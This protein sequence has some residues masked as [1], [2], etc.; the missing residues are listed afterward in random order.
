[1]GSKAESQL[2]S[3]SFVVRALESVHVGRSDNLFAFNAMD[4]SPDPVSLRAAALSTLKSKRRKPAPDKGPAMAPSRPT[5]VSDF[6]L[7]YG[8]DDVMVIDSQPPLPPPRHTSPKITQKPPIIDRD[9]QMREEGE[10][11]D[12]E[13][14]R[15]AIIP[16]K[17]SPPPNEPS[18]IATPDTIKPELDGTLSLLGPEQVRPGLLCN[19]FSLF[20]GHRLI[21]YF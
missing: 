10:I 12:E 2:C 6:Q 8:Q 13:I 3:V 20:S 5:P 16:L 19:F 1:M 4:I 21:G 17:P 9:V 18:E 15:P 14:L 7:D 11:S